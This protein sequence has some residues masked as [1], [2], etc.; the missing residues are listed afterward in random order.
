MSE[1]VSPDLMANR[2][3]ISVVKPGARQLWDRRKLVFFTL[4]LQLLT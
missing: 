1:L 2:L 3:A 4:K